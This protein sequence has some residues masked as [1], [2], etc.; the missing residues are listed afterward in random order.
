MG[1]LDRAID[2]SVDLVKAYSLALDGVDYVIDDPALPAGW[3]MTFSRPLFPAVV[4]SHL[5][6]P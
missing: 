6:D 5:V 4:P 3:K 2:L 1:T